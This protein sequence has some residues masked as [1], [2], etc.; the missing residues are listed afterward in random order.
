MAAS[1]HFKK[2]KVIFFNLKKNSSDVCWNSISLNDQTQKSQ[3]FI[4]WYG[5]WIYTP[6]KIICLMFIGKMNFT[7]F[8]FIQ[9]SKGVVVYNKISIS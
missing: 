1:L 4:I 2:Q 5:W 7:N 6:V 9:N 3:H 8:V